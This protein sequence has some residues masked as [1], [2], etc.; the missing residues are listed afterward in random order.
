MGPAGGQAQQSPV[1]D[2]EN[3]SSEAG[4][5]ARRVR[6]VQEQSSDRVPGLVPLDESGAKP[7]S[8]PPLGSSS[9]SAS[10]STVTSTYA[11]L[12]QAARAAMQRKPDAALEAPPKHSME[13]PTP[14]TAGLSSASAEGRRVDSKV[15]AL[16]DQYG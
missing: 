4:S 10:T 6:F 16:R 9:S 2:E 15:Q 8:N 7:G 14:T 13:A 1:E 3:N 5:Q 12:V 11:V